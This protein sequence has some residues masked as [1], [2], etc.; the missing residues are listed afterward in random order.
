[1]AEEVQV[2]ARGPLFD[3]RANIQVQVF[4]DDAIDLVAAFAD[5]AVDRNL[6]GSIQNP[7][8]PPYYQAQIN[9]AHRGLD[10]VVNDA[11]VVYGP[12]LEG[13]GSRNATTRFKGYFSFRRARQEV[14]AKTAALVEPALV[15]YI[16]AV[17]R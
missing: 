1:M 9:I 6:A 10:R 8:Q 13:V 4:I 16:E 12:W 7:S 14:E 2:I 3:G 5:E 17:N 15:R 11:M